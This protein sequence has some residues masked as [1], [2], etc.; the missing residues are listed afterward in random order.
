MHGPVLHAVDWTAIGVAFA[1][2]MGWMPQ[3]AG[4]MSALYIAIKLVVWLR[5]RDWTKIP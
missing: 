5:N 2:F 3:V 1:A 4:F